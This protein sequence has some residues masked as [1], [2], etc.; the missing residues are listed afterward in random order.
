MGPLMV[1]SLGLQAAGMFTQSVG[2]YFSAKQQKLQLQTQAQLSE[3]NARMAELGAR[4][5]LLQGERAQQGHMLK[6]AGLKGKQ[7]AAMAA[8]GVDLGE[9]SALNVLT[10]TDVM[11]EIDRNTIEH[12]AMMDAWGYKTQAVNLRSEA[13]MQRATASGI[14]PGLAAASTLL[15]SAGSV[16]S[17]WYTMDR[18]G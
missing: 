18:M 6:T 10:T 13:A 5:A 7:R 9:G 17:N 11:S 4:N 3:I 2:S 12:N 14:K 8:G 15:G 16:A 1:A